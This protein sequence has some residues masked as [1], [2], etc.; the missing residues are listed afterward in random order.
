MLQPPVSVEHR[1]HRARPAMAAIAARSRVAL[2]MPPRSSEIRTVRGS[3]FQPTHRRW[4]ISDPPRP[5]AIPRYNRAPGDSQTYAHHGC[6]RPRVA[7]LASA[8]L[9]QQPAPPKPDRP[10]SIPRPPVQNPQA[11]ASES[12]QR[13]RRTATR[14]FRSGR[15]RRARPRPA[16]TAAY[17]VQTFATGVDG[18]LLRFTSCPTVASCSASVPAG[19]GSSART[20]ALS[21]P[22]GGLPPFGPGRNLFEV[23]PDHDFA[24]N[25]VIYLLLHGDARGQQPIR[26]GARPAF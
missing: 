22:I 4:L 3:K 1:A 20:D 8:A 17:E 24:K 21:A 2:E 26:R 14:R 23:L 7:L 18:R 15:V 16:R 12:R 6:S 13:R 25:R 11:P 10:A 19:C 5:G 9:A